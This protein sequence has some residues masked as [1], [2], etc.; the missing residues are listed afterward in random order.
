MYGTPLVVQ[1]LRFC[2][3]AAGGVGS[4]SGWETKSHKLHG[5]TGKIKKKKER[6][7]EKARGILTVFIIANL[8][9]VL[10]SDIFELP[11]GSTFCESVQYLSSTHQFHLCRSADHIKKVHSG[12]EF[13][14]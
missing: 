9:T 8:Y 14:L 12:S 11:L 13:I 10:C 2:T 5:V 6:K 3:S 1:W 4:L 7:K